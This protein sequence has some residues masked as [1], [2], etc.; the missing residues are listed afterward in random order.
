M[1][2][3]ARLGDGPEIFHSLQGEGVNAGRPSIFVRTS[4]CN[5]HCVWCDTD[6]TWNWEG[7]TFHHERERDPGYCKFRREQEV[8]ETSVAEAANRVASFPCRDVV[9]TGGEPM[10]QQ[11]RLA[12]LMEQLRRRDPAYAF[13]VETNGTLRPDDRFDAFVAQYSV[14]PKLANSGNAAP[15]RLRWEALQWFA[16]SPKA[17]CKFVVCAP[18]DVDEI[19]ALAARLA[20]PAHRVLLMPEGRTAAEVEANRDLV[21]GL[22]LAKGYSFSDR[23]HLRLF[24]P[25]RGA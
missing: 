3:L 24:G 2:K 21:V 16:A 4:T 9:L 7:T 20:L 10:L 12:D 1:L 15:L 8:V 5:L 14:S 11:A 6:Y 19:E 17:W 23:L 18:A 25:V 13:E 22:C